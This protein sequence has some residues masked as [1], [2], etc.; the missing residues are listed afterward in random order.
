MPVNQKYAE[1]FGSEPP[2]L[3]DGNRA[4]DRRDISLRWLIGSALTGLT[5]STLMGIALFAALDGQEQLAIPAEAMTSGFI[6]D[7]GAFHDGRKSSR[8]IQATVPAKLKDRVVMEIP[9]MIQDG[10]VQVVRREPFARI[11]M[12]LAANHTSEKTYPR[13]DP[14]KMF[15]AEQSDAPAT[16]ARIGTLYGAQVES[17]VNL[18][19][20]DFPVD[21]LPA[22]LAE[23]LPASDIE[24]MVRQSGSALAANEVKVASLYYIDPAA[25]VAAI[26]G[27][28]SRSIS[29]RGWSRKM[30]PS[31]PGN[32][33]ARPTSS[34]SMI[35]SRFPKT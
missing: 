34:S 9:T 16:Q 17:E 13:F 23:I 12:A 28:I 20:T 29:M 5:S 27:S 26:S 19:V 18:K 24:E 7:N 31:Q 14:L 25:S 6:G 4:P 11:R 8:V 22:P 15:S 30:F 2:L 10:S 33:S 35:S 1:A 21:R 3:A 32:G